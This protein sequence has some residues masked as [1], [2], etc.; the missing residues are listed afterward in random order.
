MPN[1][2]YEAL[3]KATEEKQI[4]DIFNHSLKKVFLK[5]DEIIEYPYDCDG[6]IAS[7][8]VKLLIEY[9]YGVNI[10]D[11]MERAKV[12]IQV[13]YYIKKFEIN[14]EK[15]PNVIL[16]ANNKEVI[17]LHSNPLLKYLDRDL[18]WDI[19]P[20]QAYKYVGSTL[21][22]LALDNELK[23]FFYDIDNSFSIT[24]IEKKIRDIATNIHRLVK[25]TEHNL[26]RGYNYFCENVIKNKNDISTNDLVGVFIRAITDKENCYKHPIRKNTLVCNDKEFKID[27]K[28][29]D[30]FFD[31]FDSEY[32]V[33]EKKLFTEIA[34]RLLEDTKRRKSGE[35]YTPTIFA[36][37]AHKMLSEQLGEDWKEKY[38]VWD[39]CWGT[40]NLTRDY[41]FKELYCSTSEQPELEC[42]K[43]YNPE[44]TKF[45]F[46]FLNDSITSPLL[47]GNLIPEKLNQALK[48]NKPLCF[49]INPPFATASSDFSTGKGKEACKTKVTEMMTQAGLSNANKNLFAQFLYQIINIKKYFKLKNVAIGLFCNPIYLSGSAFD[50][51]REV[52]LNE[53][54]YKNGILFNA[55]HFADV[56][57]IWG[58]SFSIWQ[59]GKTENKQEFLHKIVEDDLDTIKVKGQKLLYNIDGNLTAKDWIKEPIIQIREEKVQRPTLATGISIKKNSTSHTTI[60]KSALG[61]Y[62][63]VGNDVYNSTL[64]LAL[65]TGC[66]NS[67]ANGISIMPENFERICSIFAARKLIIPTWINNKDN[68]LIPKVNNPLYQTFVANSIIFSLFHSSSNQSSLRQVKFDKNMWDINN[69]F[70]F[71]SRD[72]IMQLADKFGFD[73]T[74][75]DAQLS[76]ERYVYKKISQ[77]NLSKEATIILNNAKNLVKKSFK[78]RK[79][80]NE[81][82]PEYQIL[83]WDCGWYQIKALLKAYMPLEL[84]DFSDKFKLFSDK[85]RPIV[86]KLGFVK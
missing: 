33:K 29:F 85:L 3:K 65:F 69:E 73:Y 52:F 46:D 81:I 30:A 67:N 79:E 66:D 75:K 32:T 58:I 10:K 78:F 21:R 36:D 53:F 55:S 61:C 28:E 49:L 86:Y 5:N 19:A 41:K 22:D 64:K 8:P 39:C 1:A 20:S 72:D 50:K 43:K 80:F 84:K 34:D 48:S 17:I 44:A 76:S 35:F 25:L 31:Y 14:G 71:I 12:L 62:L 54:A 68:F 6:L 13:I 63:N 37:Y 60:F 24:L 26:S 70:F 15:L 23:T 16:L 74:F 47:Y 27:E 56:S 11:E 7:E 45:I 51:F 4:S 59:S 2:L 83:N 82:N 18:N 77:L 40:G 42:G 38:V 57:N 9:K